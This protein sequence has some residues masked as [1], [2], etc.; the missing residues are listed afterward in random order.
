LAPVAGMLGVMVYDVECMLAS[1]GVPTWHR[2][3]WVEPRVDGWRARII[4][5]AGLPE[6]FVVRTRG[7]RRLELT[8]LRPLVGLGLAVARASPGSP[9]RGMATDRRS[10]CRRTWPCREPLDGYNSA[11][12]LDPDTPGDAADPS[13]G[14]AP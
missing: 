2:D 14:S 1:Q 12:F 11:P 6:G 13:P 8:E 3:S 4:V 9:G 5:D 7:G 10:V